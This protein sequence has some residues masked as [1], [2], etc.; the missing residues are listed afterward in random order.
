M[1]GKGKNKVKKRLTQLV[2]EGVLYCD[3][4][5]RYLDLEIFNRKKCYIQSNKKSNRKDGCRYM[6]IKD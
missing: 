4:Y 5:N 2:M 6:E 3:K 1:A